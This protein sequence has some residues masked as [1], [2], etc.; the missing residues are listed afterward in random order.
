MTVTAATKPRAIRTGTSAR[1]HTVVDSPLG[2]LTL[3]GTSLG[4]CGMYM[5][6]QRH[7]PEQERFGPKDP[8]PF[9]DVAQQLA[10]YFA[11]DR[12][13]FDVPL[14][15]AGTP[16]QERVWTALQTI[17]YGETRS[18]GQLAAQVGNPSASR[19]VGMANGRNPVGII[20][21]CHRVVGSTGKLVGYGGGVERK[22]RLLAHERGERGERPM[23]DASG[24]AGPL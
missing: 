8:S 9:T 11:G 22:Q 6:L 23:L 10:E 7:L 18:Y 15:L 1:V 12:R 19:A 17:P 20:V 4:L 3:V 2:P 24:G 13:G 5:D 14:D 16:F 21:P